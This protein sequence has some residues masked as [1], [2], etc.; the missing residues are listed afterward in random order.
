MC[1]PPTPGP[2]SV[3]RRDRSSRPLRSIPCAGDAPD[4]VRRAPSPSSLSA[5]IVS[6]A[7]TWATVVLSTPLVLDPESEEGRARLALL[8]AVHD[9]EYHSAGPPFGEPLPLE[10][11]AYETSRSPREG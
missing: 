3:T 5:R 8:D 11:T 4:P 6:A 1:L 9:L 2:G 7:Q 10:F